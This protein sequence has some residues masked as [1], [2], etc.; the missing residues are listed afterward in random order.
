VVKGGG[1]LLL[2]PEPE[3]LETK[4]FGYSTA[5]YAGDCD[6][7]GMTVTIYATAYSCPAA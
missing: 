2:L 7:C 5:D 3:S 1:N 4:G 6:D